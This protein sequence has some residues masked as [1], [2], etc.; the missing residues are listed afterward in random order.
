[1][2]ERREEWR[3]KERRQENERMGMGNGRMKRDRRMNE[4]RMWEEN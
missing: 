3:E 2:V 4:L 1:M